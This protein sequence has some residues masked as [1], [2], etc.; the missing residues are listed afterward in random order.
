MS[1]IP[2]DEILESLKMRTR[3]SLCDDERMDDDGLGDDDDLL[4]SEEVERDE[5]SKME[6]DLKR[7]PR[8]FKRIQSCTHQGCLSTHCGTQQRADTL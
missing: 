2:S 5:A 8:G 3:E 1:K 7:W 4:P 6:A